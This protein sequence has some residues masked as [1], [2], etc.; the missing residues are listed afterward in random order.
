MFSWKNQ[1]FRTVQ[2]LN[3]SW[4]LAHI[5]LT[6]EENFA[7]KQSISTSFFRKERAADASSDNYYGEYRRTKTEPKQ[8]KP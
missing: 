3:T 2:S 6:V 8:V 4:I 7:S 1:N 5:E